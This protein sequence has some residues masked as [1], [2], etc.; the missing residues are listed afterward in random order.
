[1]DLRA[2]I[3]RDF[4]KPHTLKITNYIGDDPDRF[5]ELMTLFLGQEYRVTQRA[6]WVV[7]HCCDK[8]PN[9]LL[10]FLEKIIANLANDIPVAVKRN[11]VRVLQS[12]DVPEEL[13]GPLADHCF[14]YLADAKETIA[15][16]VFAMTILANIAK[17]FPDLKGEL[18]LMIEDQLPLGSAGFVNRGMKI[19]EV[20]EKL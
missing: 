3:L 14:R 1:M 16:K 6:A 17:K 7:S 13:M 8:H 11:T 5:S 18:R 15:V 9:L 10:P 4:S 2:E 12:V 20:L 19:L